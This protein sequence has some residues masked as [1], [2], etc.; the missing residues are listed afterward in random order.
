MFWTILIFSNIAFLITLFI[1]NIMVKSIVLFTYD[2]KLLKKKNYQ[3]VE[4]RTTLLDLGFSLTY[5]NVRIQHCI[6]REE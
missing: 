2:L 6:C 1:I 5:F 4:P 3:P